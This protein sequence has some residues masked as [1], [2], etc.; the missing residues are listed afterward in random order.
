M[1]YIDDDV[2][3]KS[4]KYNKQFKIRIYEVDKKMTGEIMDRDNNWQRIIAYCG[5]IAL[6]DIYCGYCI[7]QL[8][9]EKIG[10]DLLMQY[11]EEYL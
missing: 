2:L 6:H 11:L 7:Y 1:D 4:Y 10:I 8:A 5:D 3:V 9:V